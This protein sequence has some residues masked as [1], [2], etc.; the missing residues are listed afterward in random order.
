MAKRTPPGTLRVKAEESWGTP[1]ATATTTVSSITSALVLEARA[2]EARLLLALKNSTKRVVWGGQNN[3]F[4][5][6]PS[7]GLE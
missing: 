7:Q 5:N 4:L 1:T 2:S 3:F 6:T